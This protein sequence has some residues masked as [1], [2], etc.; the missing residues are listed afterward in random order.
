MYSYKGLPFQLV[1]ALHLSEIAT[2]APFPS[3]LKDSPHPAQIPAFEVWSTVQ[4]HQPRLWIA[5]STGETCLPPSCL[6]FLPILPN[7]SHGWCAAQVHGARV[8]W[9]QLLGCAG[10]SGTVTPEPWVEP[11]CHGPAH[12]KQS[13]LSQNLFNLRKRDS[14]SKMLKKQF[15]LE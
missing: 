1:K 9:P 13:S 11:L 5:E 7:R 4:S 8:I 2:E 10:R 3:S 12:E 14:K 6:S 15:L